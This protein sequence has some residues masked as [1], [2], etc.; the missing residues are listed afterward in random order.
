[1][2]GNAR[3]LVTAVLDLAAEPGARGLLDRPGFEEQRARMPQRST[4]WAWL[5]L[6]EIEPHADQ[7][8]RELR[9]ANH[10]RR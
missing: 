2:L 9:A 3:E 4:L 10:S 6:A 7:G 1:M 8:F 5:E